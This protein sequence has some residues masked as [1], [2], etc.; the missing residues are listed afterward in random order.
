MIRSYRRREQTDAPSFSTVWWMVVGA[1]VI[2][3]VAALASVHENLIFTTAIEDWLFEADSLYRINTGLHYAY[4]SL[5]SLVVSFISG[6]VIA[7]IVG[8][9]IDRHGPR[10]VMLIGVLVTGSVFLLIIQVQNELQIQGALWLIR[11]SIIAIT[12]V[13]LIGTIGKW[14]VRKRVLAFAIVSACSTLASMFSFELTFAIREYGWQ[15]LA[16]VAGVTI[17]IV[18]IPVALMMRRQPEDHGLL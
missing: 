14:F 15:I 2:S 10:S 16:I 17:L 12:S 18:G 7:P 6:V 8:F 1:A 5:G 4:T 3:F 13:V 9:V 11:I